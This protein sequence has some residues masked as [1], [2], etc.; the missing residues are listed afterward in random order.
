[1]YGRTLIMGN[2]RGKYICKWG[3]KITVAKARKASIEQGC[4]SDIGTYAA[5]V[6]PT[7][8]LKHA[9][10]EE[11]FWEIHEPDWQAW[12]LLACVLAEVLLQLLRT[13]L[14]VKFKGRFWSS[15]PRKCCISS[16]RSVSEA[17]EK[18][19]CKQMTPNVL[20]RVMRD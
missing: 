7:Q 8:A 15:D 20:Q 14:C 16:L 17:W 5:W 1:M 4:G 3:R 11:T 10:E 12:G 18:W 13:A 9:L 6:T 19:K 2:E